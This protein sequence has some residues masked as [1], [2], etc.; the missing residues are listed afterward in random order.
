M[1]DW[2][3]E[4]KHLVGE[5]DYDYTFIDNDGPT[6]F[7]RTNNDAP[8]GRVIAI[9]V[10][11]PEPE[12][13]K[14]IVPQA[15]ETLE[16]ADLVADHFLVSYLKDARTQVKVFD[17]AGKFVREVEFPG[18]GTASGFS[19]KRE[20]QE[21]FYSFTSYNTPATIYRYDV[22]SGQ[23]TRLEAAQADV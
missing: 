4:P 14:E 20:H 16:S 18:I 11:H 1:N 17:L 22:K 12:H 9:N 23:S 5:F 19:G 2:E 6:F 7:F 13:W 3:A 15:E 21:T 8:R 10:N